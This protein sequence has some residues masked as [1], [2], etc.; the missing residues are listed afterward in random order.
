MANRRAASVSILSVFLCTAFCAA[1]AFPWASCDCGTCPSGCRP[2][3]R[4]YGGEYSRSCR[5]TCNCNPSSSSFSFPPNY[6]KPSFPYYSFPRP[7]QSYYTT[8]NN[9]T[10]IP[11]PPALQQPT[12][13]TISLPP[14]KSPQPPSFWYPRQPQPPPSNNDENFGGSDVF[15][16][17][18]IA[19]PFGRC[20]TEIGSFYSGSRS[21]NEECCAT[22]L[23]FSKSCAGGD[24]ALPPGVLQYC[25]AH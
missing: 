9:P 3:K 14:P 25:G 19:V 8:P 10:P 18:N 24:Y 21:V 2:E 22:F 11:T 7:W 5:C 13:P 23:M 20:M 12:N 6:F 17:A 15:G 1:E 4:Y 16:C